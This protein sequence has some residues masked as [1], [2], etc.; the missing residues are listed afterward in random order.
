MQSFKPAWAMSVNV[1]LIMAL[2]IFQARSLNM[3]SQVIRYRIKTDSI[4]S[5]LED[6]SLSSRECALLKSVLTVIYL[7]VH[8][9]NA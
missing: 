8:F 7:V 5:G 9:R 3:G 6:V 2:N 4:A 1:C